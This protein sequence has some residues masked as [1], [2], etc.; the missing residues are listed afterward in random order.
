MRQVM[1]EQMQRR[2]TKPNKTK[3]R[4][5]FIYARHL[6]RLIEHEL[7]NEDNITDWSESGNFGQLANELVGIVTEVIE[8]RLSK[9]EEQI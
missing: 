9:E 7:K 8:Y 3:V 2:I 6:M 5:D 1:E 4:K